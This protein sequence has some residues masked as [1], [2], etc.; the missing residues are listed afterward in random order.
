M[1]DATTTRARQEA[2]TWFAKLSRLS[3][4]SEALREFHEWRR[5]PA[6]AEAYSQVEATWDAAGDLKGDA[7]LRA[8]TAAALQRSSGTKPRAA[9]F[10]W[11]AG[12]ASVAAAGAAAALLLAPTTY[13][14]TVGEQR[15]V[16]L[17][18]GTRMRLN[19]DSVV[20][21]R[22]RSAAREVELRRGEAY[23]EVA[24]DAARPFVVRS[25]GASIRDVGT[26]FDVRRRSDATQVTLLEGSVEVSGGG[27]VVTLAPNQQLVANAK[28]VSRP[29]AADPGQTTSWTTGR[30]T[31]RNLPLSAATAEVNRY[32]RRRIVLD[33]PPDLARRPVSGVFDAGD[34]KAFVAAVDTLFDLEVQGG[35]GGDIRLSPKATA[36]EG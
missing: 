2:A 1:S 28:G 18:D 16:V 23:F 29:V 4:T 24:H 32:A 6:N 13:R 27:G 31:F 9:A 35:G 3:V 7:D 36:P 17:P 20:R 11:G 25:D 30:L 5:D 26:T 33:V 34:S 22:F 14:T 10:R 8:A 21:L 12:I 15:L 19:T